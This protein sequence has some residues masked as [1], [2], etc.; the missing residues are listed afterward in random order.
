VAK[1]LWSLISNYCAF[2][3]TLIHW[4]SYTSTSIC[5]T[6]VRT[7][8]T[9]NLSTTVND[10]FG[11]FFIYVCRHTAANLVILW[12]GSYAKHAQTHR[13][14]IHIHVYR[15][16]VS[17]NSQF[18]KSCKSRNKF[19]FL[20]HWAFPVATCTAKLHLFDNS[21]WTA[22]QQLVPWHKVRDL[23]DLKADAKTC[24]CQLR[25]GRPDRQSK[26]SLATGHSNPIWTPFLISYT[27]VTLI[28]LIQPLA[29]IQNKTSISQPFRL[30]MISLMSSAAPII[31]HHH[32]FL[33]CQQMSK[34]IRRYIWLKHITIM[35][36][37]K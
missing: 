9:P 26:W 36:L 17:R 31:N 8:T 28:V 30:A 23:E 22:V 33:Y 13:R 27:T 24:L 32:S 14:F 7:S 16:G 11:Q 2:Q 3:P 19:F 12:S 29:D 1:V 21:V 10:A 25:P 5:S 20:I 15:L 37:G 6:D 34:R 35:L 4:T 18:N